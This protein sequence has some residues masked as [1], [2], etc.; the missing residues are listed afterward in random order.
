LGKSYQVYHRP[1]DRLK[2]MLW[3]GRRTFYDEFWAVR[4]VDFDVQPA[5]TVGIIGRNGAG[6]S[7]LLQ[8]VCGTLSPTEGSIR[9]QGRVA[10][11]LEL[12][13]GFNPEFTGRENVF[14]NAALLGMSDGEIRDRFEA[15]ERFADIGDFIDQPVRTYSSGM[16]ARLAFAVAI[17]C[18]PEILIIDEILAVGDAAFQ[19]KCI[20]R[21]Y[22]IRDSGCT[23]L[24]VSHDPYMVK[25]VCRRAIYLDQGEPVLFGPADEVIDRYTV[26]LER[27]QKSVPTPREVPAEPI[28]GAPFH[29]TSVRLEDEHGE[30]RQRV[31]TGESIRIRMQYKALHDAFPEKIAFVVNVY[32]HDSLYLCG[33]STLM[34]GL[35]PFDA[36]PTGEV[37]IHFPNFA[38]LSGEY[39]FR[40]AINDEEGL[41]IFAEAKYVCPIQVADD[42]QAVGMFN[43]ARAWEVRN[44]VPVAASTNVGSRGQDS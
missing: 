44:N 33:T 35:A 30:A 21:F 31:R 10:A 4:H 11:L 14:L 42:F 12:G 15:I 16:H 17:H 6:K 28:P 5:E 40:V 34:D 7:T 43:L 19:R 41:G 24:F 32:R 18:D 26:D 39:M 29:I 13:S 27:R 38:L 37:V 23:I 22:Q 8:L 2:Q 3:R 9:V 36:A 25:S 20:E 1:V